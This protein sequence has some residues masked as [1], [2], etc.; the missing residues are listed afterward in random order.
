MGRKKREGKKIERV[1]NKEKRKRPLSIKL[2]VILEKQK[3]HDYSPSKQQKMKVCNRDV[4][5][6][7][8]LGREILVR[9]RKQTRM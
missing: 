1:E 4:R 8:P 2:W 9:P 5:E 7:V 6:S 3:T